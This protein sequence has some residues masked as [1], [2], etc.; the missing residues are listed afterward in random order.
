MSSKRSTPAALADCRS[1]EGGCAAWRSAYV[2]SGIRLF[3]TV[4][5]GRRLVR[6][7]DDVAV[8]ALVVVDSLVDFFPRSRSFNSLN[9]KHNSRHTTEHDVASPC[10]LCS[11]V[12]TLSDAYDCVNQ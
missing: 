11:S 1:N 7:V 10:C 6:P 3:A 12:T 2:L 9:Y 4:R 5:P 8:N